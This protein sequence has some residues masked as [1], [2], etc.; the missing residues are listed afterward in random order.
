MISGQGTVDG[1]DSQG[2]QSDLQVSEDKKEERKALAK[3]EIIILGPA[4]PLRFPERL[5]RESWYWCPGL[6]LG[7]T[8]PR[9]W[10]GLFHL[11]LSLCV[12]KKT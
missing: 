4:V 1:V 11:S 2:N 8:L 5:M 12:E 9:L 3:E 6:L 10:S 7:Y